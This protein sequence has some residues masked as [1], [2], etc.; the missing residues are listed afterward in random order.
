MWAACRGAADRLQV[1]GTIEI[2]QVQ[3]APLTSGRLMRLLKDEGDTVHRGDTVAVLDQPGLDALIS[4]R[5]AQAEAAVLRVAEVAAAQADSTRAANDL[6]RAERLQQQ[7]II[8]AQQYDGLKAAASAAAARL[9]ARRAG[10]SEAMAAGSAVAAALATRDELVIVAPEDGVVLSRYA[11]PGEALTT[12][13][14]ILSLGL[15]H[16]P[17]IRAYVGERYVGRVKIGQAATVRV[18][19]YPGRAFPG[20]IVEIGSQAEFTPRVAL[21]ERER[22]DLV[23]GIKVEPTDGDAGGRLKAGMPVT[24]DVPLL[25]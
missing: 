11:N 5:R 18:D 8:S 24:L 10:S 25:P 13:T 6:A 4:Q 1:S 7:N 22:A 19:A 21:T 3:L 23:F 9:A 16:R 17:W 15:V 20:R 2:R 14:P 12:G